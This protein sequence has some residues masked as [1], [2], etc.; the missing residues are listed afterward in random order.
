MMRSPVSL[1]Q[2]SWVVGV[3]PDTALSVSVSMIASSLAVGQW[4]TPYPLPARSNL[5]WRDLA[6]GCRA[7]TSAW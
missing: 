1:W 4:G 2:V 3:R 7:C 6:L 5:S